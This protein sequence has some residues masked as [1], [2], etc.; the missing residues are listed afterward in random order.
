M[1]A[2]TPPPP[3]AQAQVKWLSTVS[4]EGKTYYYNPQTD[5]TTWTMPTGYNVVVVPAPT[6][7]PPQTE[8]NWLSAV[9]PE[10]KTFC[11][12]NPPTNETTWTLL[13][14]VSGPSVA[15]SEESL[16]GGFDCVAAERFL[17][18][19]VGLVMGRGMRKE[20]KEKGDICFL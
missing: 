13:P 15:V 8:S 4:P 14:T 6:P 7:P 9:S 2:P 10:G 11:Y 1:R 5:E 3:Q 18:E 12:Y 19:R 16:S 20:K 17:S